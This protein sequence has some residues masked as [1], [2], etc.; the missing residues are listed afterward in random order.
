MYQASQPLGR[1][2]VQHGGDHTI[3]GQLHAK[4][5]RDILAFRDDGTVVIEHAGLTVDV[6]ILQVQLGRVQGAVAGRAL[7]VVVDLDHTFAGERMEAAGKG[8]G[9]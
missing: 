1:D 5:P 4:K 7:V 6:I 2:L 8:V 3:R 9:G